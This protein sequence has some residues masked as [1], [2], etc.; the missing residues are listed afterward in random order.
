MVAKLSGFAATQAINVAIGYQIYEM[1]GDPISL[2]LV[3]L[4]MVVPVFFCVPF[5]GYVAD[6]FDRRLVL[7]ACNAGLGLTSMLICF[8]TIYAVE[9]L[10][11]YYLVVF[12]TGF[13]RAFYGAAS[14]AAV[15][16]LVPQEL[17]PNAISWNVS[18]IKITQ[19]GGPM[20]GGFLYLWGPEIVY[21]VSAVALFLGALLNWLT[22]PRPP[23]A[24]GEKGGFKTLFAGLFYVYRT[25]MI[26][27]AVTIDLIVCLM[28]GV[29]GLIPIFAK[30]ILDVGAS[31]AGVLRSALA[32]GGLGMALI[33]T[34]FLIARRAGFWM[35]IGVAAFGAATILF[36]VS[37]SYPLSIVALVLVG[38]ADMVNINVRHTILQIATPDALRGRVSA[39]NSFSAN[40]S[41]ELGTARGGGF[42]AVMGAGPAVVVGGAV[43]LLTAALCPK[44]FPDLA[45]VD[46]LSE[47]A[48]DS[49]QATP[50]KA[51]A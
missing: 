1:T 51:A 30:D 48:P 36:G 34:H 39:V 8:L 41:T 26:L 40:V 9:D 29:Q 16:S 38:A 44:L 47:L 43:I 4:A 50:P 23:A 6:I 45:K 27:G 18:I 17:A 5:V 24:K 46:R 25:K 28:G 49:P 14:N 33:L 42:A 3:G 21:G 2:A 13:P 15:P 31:G 32:F 7:T 35:L 20:L 19:I 37:T 10:W 22:K 12:L 11:P